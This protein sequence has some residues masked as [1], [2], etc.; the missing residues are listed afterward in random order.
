MSEVVASTRDPVADIVRINLRAFRDAMGLTQEQAA[1]ISG[2]P[3]D[4]IR[5]WETKGGIKLGAL[6]RL[7]E[8]YKR[9]IGHFSM[10][11]PPK[12]EVQKPRIALVQISD[13]VDPEI[14]EQIQELMLKANKETRP[15][16]KKGKK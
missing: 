12:I 2:L 4:S 14:M 3:I 1:A 15:A 8:V 16:K 11:E 6:V 13:D 7:A 10:K 5:R 9:D